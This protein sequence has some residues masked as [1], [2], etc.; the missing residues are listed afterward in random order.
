MMYLI[1]NY[2]DYNKE[3]NKRIIELNTKTKKDIT[4]LTQ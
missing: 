4:I 1:T 2:D 3:Q